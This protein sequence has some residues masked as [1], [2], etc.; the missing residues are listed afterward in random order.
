M[1]ELVV[2]SEGQLVFLF[3]DNGVIP[4]IGL[5]EFFGVPTFVSLTDEPYY[6]WN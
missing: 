5:A 1:L 4:V 6:F 3:D 2:T